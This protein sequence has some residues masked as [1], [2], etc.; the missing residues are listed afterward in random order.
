MG[1]VNKC[2]A[3]NF[4]PPKNVKA[5]TQV[6]C[7]TMIF[8]FCCCRKMS[9]YSGLSQI[10]CELPPIHPN[11]PKL[12]AI[13]T[14][15]LQ[16][17]PFA[18]RGYEYEKY[19]DRQTTALGK[20]LEKKLTG[21]SYLQTEAMSMM[22]NTTVQG[23]TGKPITYLV[24]GEENLCLCFCLSLYPFLVFVTYLVRGEE[25]ICRIW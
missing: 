22:R 17:P 12:I 18:E 21:L 4:D 16:L 5:C 11:Y 8:V 20:Y 6:D 13:S 2:C 7:F 10:K 15:R 3:F 24:R 23:R 19:E 9:S 1:K 25:N 14:N